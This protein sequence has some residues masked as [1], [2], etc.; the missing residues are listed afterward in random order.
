M[1]QKI[2]VSG[3]GPYELALI[4]NGKITLKSPCFVGKNGITKQK[5]EGDGA[6]PAGIFKIT[7]AFGFAEDPGFS[8]PYI[9][10]NKYAYLVDD[11]GSK[12]YNQI[13]D[14][15]KIIPDF[16]SAEKMSEYPEYKYGAVIGYNMNN[17]PGLGSGIFLHCA[18][19]PYTLGCVSAPEDVIVRILKILT[20]GA[21]I[22]TM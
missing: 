21:E 6:T 10:I 4:N 12:Y 8:L 9:H 3:N 1:T 20:P 16:R 2:I 19:E 13:V 18:R 14:V 11:P 5:R 15:R 17:I 22:T 7:A